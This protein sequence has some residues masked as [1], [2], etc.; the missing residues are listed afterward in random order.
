MDNEK[1]KKAIKLVHRFLKTYSLATI[2]GIVL[3]FFFLAKYENCQSNRIIRNSEK[4]LSDRD[5]QIN[6]LRLQIE[7]DKGVLNKVE[8]DKAEL[9]AD[10][11]R[12]AGLKEE[13]ITRNNEPVKETTT[14]VEY[15]PLPSST[16]GSQFSL[17]LSAYL[18]AD[19][20]Y[21]EKVKL[22]ITGYEDTLQEKDKQIN[23]LKKLR[24]ILSRRK[25]R[26]SLVAGPGVGVSASGRFY[27]G[28][29]VTFGF[30]LK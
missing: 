13:R 21:E 20:E 5:T 2:L 1:L 30:R 22:I 15:I 14:T 3:I 26:F 16:T 4:Y 25:R 12:M 6:I 28:L 7:Q 11:R 27:F 9:R 29:N 18:K 17:T 24:D 10:L 8:K 19:E 23:H